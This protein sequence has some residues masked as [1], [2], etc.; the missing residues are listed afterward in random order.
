M[1][2]RDPV[3]YCAATRLPKV[4]CFCIAQGGS[5]VIHTT[6]WFPITD[7]TPAPPLN[8]S[9]DAENRVVSTR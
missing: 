1:P 4:S 5:Q 6:I 8:L 3:L 2:L 9:A 7:R